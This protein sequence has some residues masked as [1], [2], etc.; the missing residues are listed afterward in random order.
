MEVICLKT[1][2]VTLYEEVFALT[3]IMV[4]KLNTNVCH[5]SKALGASLT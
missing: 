1:Y 5:V 4:M 2:R 3:D